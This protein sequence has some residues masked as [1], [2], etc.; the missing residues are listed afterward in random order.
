M[1]SAQ[2]R[3]HP[4]LIP[5]GVPHRPLRA[6][7]GPVTSFP[8]SQLSAKGVQREGRT[9]FQLRGPLRR[10]RGEGGDALKPEAQ[11]GEPTAQQAGEPRLSPCMGSGFCLRRRHRLHRDDK[12]QPGA[13]PRKARRGC[14]RL[15]C[16]PS[17]SGYWQRRPSCW[18]L[19]S[20][21]T[22]AKYSV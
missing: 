21:E 4:L 18:A 7:H 19:V 15:G 2:A 17:F 12:A 3:G 16:P 13:T 22:F 10:S 6:G 11:E 8:Q 20:A 9:H 1:V 5:L 14:P